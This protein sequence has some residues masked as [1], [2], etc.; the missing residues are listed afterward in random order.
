MLSSD[1]KL[2]ALDLDLMIESDVDT[3]D[4]RLLD[5]TLIS[6]LDFLDGPRM[7]S[8]RLFNRSRRERDS[9]STN[10]GAYNAALS[11]LIA[12]ISRNL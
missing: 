5:F 2:S 6:S 7:G 1:F 10:D 4:E 3:D 9:L 11:E 12:L 8:T